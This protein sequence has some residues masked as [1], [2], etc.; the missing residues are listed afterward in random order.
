M[1]SLRRET[2]VGLTEFVSYLSGTKRS[3]LCV[4]YGISLRNNSG[5]VAVYVGREG[6]S[7]HRPEEYMA[8]LAPD[9]VEGGPRHAQWKRVPKRLQHLWRSGFCHHGSAVC[10]LRNVPRSTENAAAFELQR[11]LDE[12][13]V[14]GGLLALSPSNAAVLQA[15]QVHQRHDQDN[16][17][18]CGRSGH[19]AKDC[20]EA[21][22]VQGVVFGSRA[23]ASSTSGL[24]Q[25]AQRTA[26]AVETLA[27]TSKQ[28]AA[29]EESARTAEL[30]AKQAEQQASAA[31]RAEEAR[32]RAEARRVREEQEV[33]EAAAQPLASESEW[34]SERGPQLREQVLRRR[35][36]AHAPPA[37]YANSQEH[38]DV[39]GQDPTVVV[40]SFSGAEVC[41]GYKRKN[42][43]W[44]DANEVLSD[45][46]CAGKAASN[47]T[48]DVYPKHVRNA[49]ARG[50]LDGTEDDYLKMLTVRAGASPKGYVV[51]VEDFVKLYAAP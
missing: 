12:G 23:A 15:C 26:L 1:R 49:I 29:V 35:L 24:D 41:R 50:A 47:W 27:E 2:A 14:V 17:V 18:A 16:C 3:E 20:E 32:E 51:R 34:K 9:N 28:Y 6:G 8:A 38:T 40:R 30:S 46:A 21:P 44:E 10:E 33:R 37:R 7:P 45:Q 39:F 48:R 31:V 36:R 5:Q 13:R 22:G 19:F 25:A 4:V 43:V 11:L 42:K